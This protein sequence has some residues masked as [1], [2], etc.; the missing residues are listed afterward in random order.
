M[1]EV[2]SF[3]AMRRPSAGD[4][5][6]RAP[7]T[8][9]ESAGWRILEFPEAGQFVAV[10]GWCRTGVEVGRFDP[11]ADSDKHHAGTEIAILTNCAADE[12]LSRC[13]IGWLNHGGPEIAILGAFV[14]SYGGRYH[15]WRDAVIESAAIGGMRVVRLLDG[16]VAVGREPEPVPLLDPFAS[17]P[18]NRRRPAFARLPGE[19]RQAV[20]RWADP[21]GHFSERLRSSRFE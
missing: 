1:G 18:D 6:G 16:S 15:F 2:V 11:R 8:V 13:A 19:I 14:V 4:G 21:R 10:S 7:A 3:P 9:F 17:L 20:L 12:K 5:S